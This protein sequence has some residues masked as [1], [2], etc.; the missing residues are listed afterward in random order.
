MF[1]LAI[2]GSGFGGS[3][4][5]LVARKLGLDVVLLERGTHPRFAIGESSTP[6]SNILIES[7]ARDFDLPRLA[8]LSRYGTWKKTYPEIGVGPKRGFS[9]YGHALDRPFTARAD[10][11]DQLLAE[12]SPHH[13]VADTHWYR[14]DLDHFLVREAAAAGVEYVDRV[15]LDSFEL[16]GASIDLSHGTG[17]RFARETCSGLAPGKRSG[18][19]PGTSS[20]L[21]L[22]R[23]SGPLH[24]TDPRPGRG[25]GSGSALGTVCRLSGTRGGAPFAVDARFVIDASGPRGFFHR[26]LR[27][28]AAR[29]EGFP[30]T[31]ALLTHFTGVHRWQDVKPGVD[32]G[33]PPYPVDDAA[34]HHIFDGGWMYVLRFD[35][36][37][38]S[39]GFALEDRLAKELRLGDGAEA[40]PRILER[41]PSIRAQ[42]A[43]ATPVEP[44]MHMPRIAFRTSV[45]GGPGWTMLPSAAASIDPLFSTG[46]PLTL[47]GIERIGRAIRDAWGT[48]EFEPRMRAHE[49]DTLF[50]ADAAASLVGAA[51]RSFGAF[52]AFVGIASC[53]LA[54]VSFAEVCFRLGDRE[55]AR[56]FLACRDELYVSHFAGIAADASRLA[57]GNGVASDALASFDARVA[58]AVEPINVAGFCDPD[59]RGWYPVSFQALIDASSKLGRTREEVRA[60]LVAQGMSRWL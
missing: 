29:F 10:R 34:L 9:F 60:F 23:S 3:L 17:S 14:P 24:A 13:D 18:R 47:L 59:R 8:P 41:L 48:P 55:R 1:D 49:R 53:Y 35:N 33:E 32:D 7:I 58:R 25:T 39:A 43:D 27:L 57:R 12:A 5:A 11:R 38:T 21:A 52:P 16:R 4:T 37:I 2:V 51:Y 31:Q 44:W 15:E 28:P 6:M 22:G 30:D 45:A 20:E 54:S 46:L 56:G 36:G 26:L 50:E 40:W 19:R 42:F